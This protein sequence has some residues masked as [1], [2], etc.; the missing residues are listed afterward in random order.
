[1]QV[2]KRITYTLILYPFWHQDH[3]A[4]IMELAG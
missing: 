1:M 4:V 2:A 3:I